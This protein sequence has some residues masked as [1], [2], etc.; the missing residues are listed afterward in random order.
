ML[1]DLGQAVVGVCRFG[2]LVLAHGNHEGQNDARDGGVNTGVKEEYPDHKTNGQQDKPGRG[3]GEME[4]LLALAR[5]KGVEGNR[6]DRERQEADLQIGGVEEGDDGDSDEV[7]DHGQG[8]QEGAQ[9]RGQMGA[10]DGED[11]HGKGDVG[12]RGNSPAPESL[13]AAVEVDQYV[14]DG[15]QDNAACR[16]H[17]GHQGLTWVAQVALHEFFFEFQTD[18][19]E[20]DR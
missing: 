8:E 10:N 3:G 15:G 19:E 9:G 1:H 18:Q 7:I 13:R 5:D 20:E 16:C 11:G 6:N 17:D 4:E 12:C 14:D 2:A